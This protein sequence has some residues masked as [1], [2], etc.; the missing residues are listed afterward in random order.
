LLF[1][2]LT[3]CRFVPELW[4]FPLFL[5]AISPVAHYEHRYSQPFFL[6]ITPITVMYLIQ[7]YRAKWFRQI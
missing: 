3:R 2:W 5:L 4:L 6:F 7:R 1:L